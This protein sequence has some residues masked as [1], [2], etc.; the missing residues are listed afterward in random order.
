[1]TV[2]G[3]VHPL[4]RR[5]ADLGA[6]NPDMELD[7]IVLNTGLSTAQQN[8]METL[9]GALQN[10]ASAQYHHWLTQEEFGARFGLSDADLDKVK[11]WLRSEGFTVERVASSR[12]AIY[13]RGTAGQVESAFH[14]QLRQYGLG[15]RT[16]FANATE[17]QVPAGIAQVLL[18][19]RGLNNFRLKPN[20]QRTSPKMKTEFT[21]AAGESFLTP[22]DW[23]TIYD[24]LPIYSAGYD[25][26]GSD[27]GVVGQTYAP[28]VDIDNF[29]QAA[30]LTAT[31]LTYVCIDPVTSNCTGASAISTE[32]DLGEADLDIEWSGGIA[33]NAMVHFVYAPYSDVN[34]TANSLGVFDAL[35]YAVES[36]KVPGTGTVLP[37]IS[38][39]YTDCESSMYGSSGAIDSGY[40]NYIMSI[41][42]QANSQGQTIVVASGDSGAAGCDAQGEAADVPAKYGAWVNVPDDSPNYTAVGGTALSGDSGDPSAYWDQTPEQVVTA[43]QYIPETV[44]NECSGSGLAASGGGVSTVFPQPGW[45]QTPSGYLGA[46]GRFVPDV[47]FAAAGGHNS[48]MY[49]SEDNDSAAYGKMCANGFWSSGGSE[50]SVFYSV[51][52]TS[53]ATPSF[54]GMLTLLT[55]KYGPQGN[56]NPTLYKLAHNAATYSTVFHDITGGNNVVPCVAGSNGCA[57]GL[58][59]WNAGPGYDM[60]TGLGSIDGWQL[61]VALGGPALAATNTSVTATNLSSLYLGQTATLTA[62]VNSATAGSITGVVTFKVAGSAIGSAQLAGGTAT[63]TVVASAANQWSTGPNTIT[64]VFGG[65]ADFAPSFGETT[66]TVLAAQATTATVMGKL[67]SVMAGGTTTLTAQVTSNGPGTITGT[68]TFSTQSVILGTASVINGSATLNDV[69]VNTACGLPPGADTIIASYGGDANFAASSGT[70]T[71]TVTAMPVTTPLATTTT[72]AVTPGSATMGG[73]VTLTAGVTAATGGTQTG[74]QSVTQSVTQTVTQTGTV[75]F[76]VNGI[77][78]GYNLLVDGSATMGNLAV[79]AANGFTAGTNSITATYSGD[80]NFAGSSSAVAT[81]LVTTLP[82]TMT[83]AYSVATTTPSVTMKAGGSA[84]VGLTVTSSYY[85][86]TVNFVVSCNSPAISA[87]ASST[88]VS[89]GGN[90][91]ST[92]TITATAS[93]AKRAPGIPWKGGSVLFCAVLLGAPFRRR[94]RTYAV[95]LMAGAITL[96]GLAMACGGGGTSGVKPTPATGSQS[97][98]VTLTPAGAPAGENPGV[99]TIAVIVEQ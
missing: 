18:N 38:M 15:Q 68:V 92:L 26:T 80:T 8:D 61:Y 78:I 17:L 93:A 77:S 47:A 51:G 6:V 9:L 54:A 70:A 53:A 89:S 33:R 81:L 49:C 85:T 12:N 79:T 62:T 40:Y 67:N 65:D 4:T 98:T 16:H 56:L 88:G 52:G 10:P 73:A 36:Y 64:A 29:R 28:Q 83:P 21:Y 97:Y 60:A 76:S 71:L 66:L 39:S 63:L 58:L 87:S 48:Y 96:A 7:G 22:G 69:T 94:K 59:G 57:N 86:G 3:S 99:I 41:G 84:E 25:G 34:R 2:A 30:G 24:V 75:S 11:G 95:L 55:Q 82:A 27:V 20:V 23:A 19:V 35:Q 72:L 5:A 14:T 74:T 42:Q 1:V 13:F 91:T 50:E 44:W 43:L 45:Q 32:G 31:K 90:N 37:V 46:S